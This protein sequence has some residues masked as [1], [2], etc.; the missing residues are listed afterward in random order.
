MSV[1]WGNE[2]E[3]ADYYKTQFNNQLIISEK[4]E[5]DVERLK[6]LLDKKCDICIERKETKTVEEFVE[7]LK[8][9]FSHMEYT[10]K[11]NRKT[12]PV[13][14]VKAEVDAVLQ[15]GCAIIID[16]VLKELEDKGEK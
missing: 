16:K 2:T 4:L 9:K 7:R 8:E 11:A 13:E 12:I 5:A 10:I 6:N 14:R 3:R 1:A 15:N